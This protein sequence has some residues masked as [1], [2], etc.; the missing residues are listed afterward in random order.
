MVLVILEMSE[1]SVVQIGEFYVLDISLSFHLHDVTIA[2]NTFDHL[3][4]WSTRGPLSAPSTH[5]Q[6]GFT[7]WLNGILDLMF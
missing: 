2:F 6:L 3:N 5:S 1:T 4:A 7:F